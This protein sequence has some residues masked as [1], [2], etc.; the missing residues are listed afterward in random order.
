[1]SAKL[2][3]PTLRKWSTE[4]PKNNTRVLSP[5]YKSLIPTTPETKLRME[6]REQYY[7]MM[8][9]RL[10]IKKGVDNLRKGE[11]VPY[12]LNTV[13]RVVE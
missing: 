5:K 2:T 1:M 12:L 4:S 10:F 11:R 9:N 6:G 7:W 13:M 8:R 3:N